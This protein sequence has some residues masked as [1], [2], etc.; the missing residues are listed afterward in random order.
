MKISLVSRA[1]PINLEQ[2]VY[3]LYQRLGMFIS[4]MKDMAEVDMLFYVS[5]QV[6]VDRNFIDRAQ[7]RL[8][9]HWG[10]KLKLSLCPINTHRPEVSRVGHY[11]APALA[12]CRN[13]AFSPTC[14]K[15]QLEALRKLISRGTDILFI[16]RLNC[17]VPVIK[18][19]LHLPP[20]YFD[21]DDVEHIAYARMLRRPPHWIL[22]SLHYLQIPLY[23]KLERQ[24]IRLSRKTFVCSETDRRYLSKL[25][26]AHNI[27][28]VPNGV[29]IPPKEE[30]PQTPTVLFIGSFTYAPNIMAADY[31]ITR[32][33]PLVRRQIPEASL[34]IAGN[35]PERIPSFKAASDGVHFVGFAENLDDLYKK[36]RI[37]CC[38]IHAAG[39]T[40][41]K[42]IEAAAYGKPVV[43]TSVGAEGLQ[44]CDGE[45]IIIRES[46]QQIA[47]ACARLLCDYDLARKIGENARDF[48]HRHYERC[49]IIDRIKK[50]LM[51]ESP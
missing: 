34:L 50:I 40:R 22:K 23:M 41:I 32:I 51:R 48:A 19:D 36:V 20:V 28:V 42:I 9:S 15:K 27:E 6:P 38:P 26:N 45:H 31:L 35:Y 16:H 30:L 10:V 25:W 18:M 43:S 33:W 12:V 47:T 39:G 44:M 17:M 14:G 46:P 49:C 37:V 7:N 4:A 3:G 5:D 24:A 29:D 13:P 21:L 11:L 1:F 8:S 2:S